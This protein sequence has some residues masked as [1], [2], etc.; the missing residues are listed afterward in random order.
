MLKPVSP[1]PP[2]SCTTKPPTRAPTIPMTIVIRRPPG[3]LPGTI[4]L[5]KIP[6][7]S[8]TKI[9]LMTPIPINSCPP[10]VNVSNV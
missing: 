2:R 4:S 3:S 8:P 6:A 7:M 1:V 9:Q 5:A 10:W